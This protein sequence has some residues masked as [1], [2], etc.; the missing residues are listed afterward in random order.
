VKVEPIVAPRIEEP[1]NIP[2]AIIEE[3]PPVKSEEKKKNYFEEDN[4]KEKQDLL[5]IDKKL[6]EIKKTE[7]KG[8]NLEVSKKDDDISDNYDDDFDEIEEDLPSDND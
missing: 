6:E 3:L 1:L 2:A 8:M 7:E 5:S 4:K